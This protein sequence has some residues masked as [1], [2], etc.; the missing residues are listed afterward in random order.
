MLIFKN[1]K[2]ENMVLKEEN[3]KNKNEIFNLKCQKEEN[4][5]EKNRYINV[6]NTE[7]EDTER[8][9]DLRGRGAEGCQ[10]S[11]QRDKERRS[12]DKGA[13]GGHRPQA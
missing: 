2:I 10:I 1:E 4:D 8:R 12:Q 5:L 3:N 9:G 11:G 7:E 6:I 13:P